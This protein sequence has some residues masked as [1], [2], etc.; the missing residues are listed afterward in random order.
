MTLLLGLLLERLLG[1]PQHRLH[2][3][4][5]FGSWVSWVEAHLYR[6]SRA[7]GVVGWLLAVVPPLLLLLLLHHYCW[8]LSV[9]AGVVCDALLL[10]TALGWRSLFEHVRAVLDSRDE[11]ARRQAVSRIVSRDS[12][13]ME[14][15]AALRAA[16]ESLAENASDAVVAP[17]FWFVV[18]GPVGAVLYRMINTLDAMWGYRTSRFA[19]FGTAAARIDDAANWLPARLTAG[20]FLLAGRM[21]DWPLLKLQA[22]SHASPNA[23][24]PEATLAFAADV[25]LGGPV[26]RQGVVDARPWYGSAGAREADAAAC[27]EA[28]RI[29]RTALLAAALLALAVQ[30][31]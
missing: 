12:E 30:Y 2:P 13:S 7:A 6:N 20:L 14:S 31:V 11:A 1:D 5:L 19:R 26:M 9:W 22:Q 27:D 28:L 21:P 4:A 29:V 17:L 15:G 3:V 10:W 18:A 8:Q 24:W 16:I 25:R 23:G